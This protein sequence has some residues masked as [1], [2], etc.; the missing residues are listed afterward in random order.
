M[1]VHALNLQRS[2]QSG[3]PLRED[4]RVDGGTVSL[5]YYEVMVDVVRPF[6]EA[7]L[8]LACAMLTKYRLLLWPGCLR[9]DGSS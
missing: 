3:E 8:R 1:E 4:V 9:L 5:G 7:L 2:G 6:C